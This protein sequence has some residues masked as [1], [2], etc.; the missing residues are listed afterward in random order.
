[1]IMVSLF[2]ETNIE[3]VL[4]V[5]VPIIAIVGGISLAFGIAY[6]RSRERLELISRGVDVSKL[7]NTQK[8]LDFLQNKPGYRGRRRSPLRSG[9]V[10]LGAGLGLLTA[11]YIDNTFLPRGDHPIIYFGFVGLFVGTGL[12]LSH[13]LEKKEPVEEQKTEV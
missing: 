6:L 1:M 12:V 7:D 10:W 9:L 2:D 11:Y 5:M 3:G 8:Y 4:G 13:L